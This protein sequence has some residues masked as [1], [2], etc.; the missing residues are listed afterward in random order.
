M[1]I[2]MVDTVDVEIGKEA[3]YTVNEEGIYTFEATYEEKKITKDIEVNEIS[4]M[5]EKVADMVIN[6]EALVALESLS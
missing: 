1:T 5:V 6:L 2:K 3:I 4:E